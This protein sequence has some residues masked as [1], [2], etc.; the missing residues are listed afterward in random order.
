MSKRWLFMAAWVLLIL[1]VAT[2]AED[3]GAL[4]RVTSPVLVSGYVLL[5]AIVSPPARLLRRIAIGRLAP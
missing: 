3:K 4:D 2:A 1:V 5:T